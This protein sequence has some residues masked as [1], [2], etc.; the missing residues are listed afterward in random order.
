MEANEPTIL[1]CAC[2]NANIIPAE[3]RARVRAALAR[4]AARVIEVPDL[5]RLAANQQIPLDET[6]LAGRV[7]V[8]ACYPRAVRWLLHRAGIKLANDPLEVLNMRV[9][10][11]EEII[12]KLGAGPAPEHVSSDPIEP[13]PDAWIP[14]FPVIDYSRCRN[15]GQ[16]LNFCL[17]DVFTSTE[18]GRIRASNPQGCKNNCPACARICPEAAII[19][20]K[21]DEEPINGAQIEDEARVR[22]KI[23][24]N[25][26]QILGN[27]VYAALAA[28]RR[29]AKLRLLKK[30]DIARAQHERRKCATEHA[31]ALPAG[32]EE[33]AP[34]SGPGQ[35]HAEPGPPGAARRRTGRD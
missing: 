24:L 33:D 5:C 18:E 19:F 3:T 32:T 28:R 8:V 29:K 12:E 6:A 26:E 20:P 10:S 14:W 25:V 34:V 2:A 22:G 21:L 13:E 31:D 17:F 7:Q 16:C 35:A 9:L 1:F 23:K 11:A 4:S 30:R 15:C 27:D